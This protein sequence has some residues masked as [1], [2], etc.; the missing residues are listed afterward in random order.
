MAGRLLPPEV[1]FVG[2]H[3]LAGKERQGIDHADA[4]LFRGKGYAIVAPPAADS[5]AVSTVLS[6]V[7]G[8]GAQPL[9]LQ[10]TEHDQYAA[11]ISHLPLVISTALFTLA[12]SSTAWPDLSATAA[13]AFRDL[14]RLASGDPT[15]SRD[16]CETNREALLHWLDRYLNELD[17]Y[18]Q[19][20]AQ[21]S[22][23]LLDVF[24]TAQMERD[25]F[26]SGTSQEGSTPGE[27]LGIRQELLS[28]LV[29]KAMIDRF[30]NRTE[31]HSSDCQEW[32][33]CLTK[34]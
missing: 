26:L 21:G 25:R 29:G 1:S 10:A 8:V 16:I 18:R 33:H 11:A 32:S 30:R 20:I 15:M 9:P 34:K 24:M 17:R 6:I 12:R 28:S 27:A 13:S 23:D 7:H 5:E 3:P 22:D 19:L 14:T 2:G 4:E 31:G